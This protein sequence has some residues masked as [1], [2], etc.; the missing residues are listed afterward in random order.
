MDMVIIDLWSQSVS[1]YSDWIMTEAHASISNY[2]IYRLLKQISVQFFS[3]IGKC[4]SKTKDLFVY[5]RF[6]DKD[7]S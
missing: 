7:K 2:L 1:F 6:W 3:F 5:R 4:L